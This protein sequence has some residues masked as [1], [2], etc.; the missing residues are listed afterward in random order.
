[1]SNA[2]LAKYKAYG[3]KAGWLAEDDGCPACLANQAA[4]AIEPGQ[5]FPSGHAAPPA[6]RDCRCALSASIL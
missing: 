3:V 2:T 6:H 4:A 1:M 5:R